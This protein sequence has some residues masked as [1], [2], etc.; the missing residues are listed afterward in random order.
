MFVRIKKWTLATIRSV[1]YGVKVGDRYPRRYSLCAKSWAEVPDSDAVLLDQQ[2]EGQ[3][4]LSKEPTPIKPEK[5]VYA[6]QPRPKGKDPQ[7]TANYPK[8]KAGKRN[9]PEGD[10]EVPDESQE[11]PAGQEGDEN[12]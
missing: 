6:N 11:L 8:P 2:N 7:N 3:L 12:P 4:V 5:V 9:A 1:S 10:P